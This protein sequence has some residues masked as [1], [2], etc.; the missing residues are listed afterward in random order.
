MS[1]FPHPICGGG[2]N[3]KYI[4][5]L[6]MYARRLSPVLLFSPALLFRHFPVLRFPSRRPLLHADRQELGSGGGGV[7]GLP[8]SR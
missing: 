1:V 5:P 8:A 2:D 6:G 4:N 7:W 3:G